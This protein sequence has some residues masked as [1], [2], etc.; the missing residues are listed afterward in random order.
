MVSH[1]RPSGPF[2][3]LRNQ[4]PRMPAVAVD[5]VGN[6][7]EPGH[8]VM[9][10]NTQQFILEVVDVRPVLNPGIPEGQSVV[11]VTLQ[12]PAFR[13]QMAGASPNGG[14]VVIG[15]SEARMKAEAEAQMNG[16]GLTPEPEAEPETQGYVE[17]VDPAP[18]SDGPRLVLTDPP[19][20]E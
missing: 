17:P 13:V 6:M 4:P 11:Q 1:K 19:K 20:D 5:R 9:F 8:L 12:M 15:K 10:Q 18:A 2:A 16:G 14:L 3:P 7:I